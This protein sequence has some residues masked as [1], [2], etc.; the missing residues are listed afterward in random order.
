MATIMSLKTLGGYTATLGQGLGG[1]GE[2]GEASDEKK[3]RRR[4]KEIQ[5]SAISN[6]LLAFSCI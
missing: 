3:K 6:P 5:H 4:K 1:G 2:G